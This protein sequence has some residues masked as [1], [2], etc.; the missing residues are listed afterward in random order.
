M[1]SNISLSDAGVATSRR[2]ALLCEAVRTCT[3]LRVYRHDMKAVDPCYELQG[4]KHG[5][6]CGQCD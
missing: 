6:R 1:V 4:C 3:T 2:T 5:S